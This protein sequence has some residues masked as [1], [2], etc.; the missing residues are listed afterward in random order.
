MALPRD[1]LKCVS[2]VCG[3]GPPDISMRGADWLHWCAF[4]IGWRYTPAF[5]IRWFWQLGPEGRLDWS[6]E[7][8]LEVLKQRVAKSANTVHKKELELMQD[9]DILQLFLRSARESFAQGFDGVDQ[10]GRVV[11]ADFGFRLEEIRPDLPVQLWYGTHD[12]FIPLNVGL[13][14]AA[15]LGG[16]AHLTAED[17]THGS[18][19]Q[20]PLMK[21]K[22]IKALL[23]SP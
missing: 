10:D 16:R 9:V 19:S 12:T 17:E 8:R 7:K 11:C 1:K 6:D 15:R 18:I 13:Q 2:I 22:I 3:L 4:P 21:E 20:N 5:L 14:I 23:G